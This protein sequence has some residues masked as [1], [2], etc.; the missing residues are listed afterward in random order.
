MSEHAH[1]L[2]Q[3]ASASDLPVAERALLSFYETVPLMMGV[4][5]LPPD[6]SDILHVYD[7]P[8]TERFF[9]LAA[10]STTGKRASELGVPPD[11]IKVWV[12]RYRAA[13][14]ERRPIRFEYDHGQGPS[15]SRLAVIVNVVGPAP[16]GWSRFSYVTED[17]TAAA[18]E[19]R[20]AESRLELQAMLADA[21]TAD[22]VLGWAA[23]RLGAHF[24]VADLR[25]VALDTASGRPVAVSD[26]AAEDTSPIVLERTSAPVTLRVLSA[27][28]TP[29]EWLAED[30]EHLGD[31]A[32]MICVRLERVL[33]AERTAAQEARLRLALEAAFLISFEWDI[34]R[35]EVHRFHSTDPVLGPTTSDDSPAT[36]EAVRSKVHP[37]DRE[38]FT[39]AVQASLA[40]P[41]GHYENEYRLIHLDGTVAHLYE[42][43][44]VERDEDGRPL[45]LIGLSQDITQR[46]RAELTQQ[47]YASLLEQSHDA[48]LVRKVGGGITYWSG[49]AE[50]LYG[51]SQDEAI[52][53]PS[54]ML[55]GTQSDRPIEEI[56]RIVSA[57][58]WWRGRLVHRTRDGRTVVVSSRWLRIVDDDG[59]Y[60]LETNRDITAQVNAEQEL[61]DSRTFLQSVFDGLGSA[62]VVLDETGRIVATNRVWQEM[63][64]GGSSEIG[65]AYLDIC[66]QCLAG[67]PPVDLVTDD[68]RALLSGERS[69]V[70]REYQVAQAAAE[71]WFTLRGNRFESAG[72]ARFVLSHEEVTPLKQAEL[73]LRAMDRR[74][75]E[76]IAI[77]AHELRNPLSP[78]RHGAGVLRARTPSDPVLVRCADIIERQTAHMAHL[79]EDLLDV[80]RLSRG[81]FVLRRATVWLHEVIDLAIEA[82]KPLIDARQH[83][84]K[85][86]RAAEPA[87][88]TGDR[89]RLVQ[90]FVNL[91][92]NAAHYSPPGS[93][94][95]VEITPRGHEVA[96]AVRDTG[97]G[98]A[99]EMRERVF[100]L[101][102]RADVAGATQRGLGIGL[103]LVRMLVELHGGTIVAESAGLG[104]GSV[105]TVTLPRLPAS[106]AQ[107]AGRAGDDA[108][109][110]VAARRTALVVDDNIDAADGL[111]MLLMSIGCDVQVAYDGPSALKIL[112]Q[113]RP[114]VAF[115]DIGMPG[116]D[117]FETCRRI[118]AAWPSVR[119]VAV[120]G[121]GHED[122]RAASLSA[123][124]DAH[125]VKPAAADAL[126]AQLLLAS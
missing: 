53:Q 27:S 30:L 80:S 43:G 58:G 70:T 8:A 84:L 7:N 120:T 5:D 23:A 69:S 100:E 41:D 114:D 51:Y 3:V 109:H 104:Q 71:R 16:G 14:R 59:I 52:G 38:R 25:L 125:L 19:S 55:F 33:A 117:G 66:A 13:E 49:G 121:W 112:E 78:I 67:C 28:R 99:P 9:G 11:T 40:R 76:F 63:V 88:V 20:Y 126:M 4:V 119:V 102:T 26:S 61:A 115:L 34:V 22:A 35:D 101:F 54:H 118:K 94:L 106:E 50:Q 32:T 123:G 85:V 111:A 93:T 90:V 73:E 42:R 87:A 64:D 24:G 96:V 39:A 57:D 86:R 31:L 12:D 122:V 6:D 72:A 81:Q 105:F 95:T 92:T 62:V 48:I 37:D 97:V 124:F 29:G 82:S 103:S 79:L 108:T 116:M 44:R 83:H 91:L 36:F 77:L 47:R 21:A 75:N 15:R 45:R 68:I 113:F 65:Q 18:R 60:T 110:H 46:K 74:K 17:I 1:P 2:G 107:H 10:G 56:E 89:E 98:L